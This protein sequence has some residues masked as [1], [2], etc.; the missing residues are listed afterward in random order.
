MP[1]TVSSTNCRMPKCLNAQIHKCHA[2]ANAQMSKCHTNA[3]QMQ[4]HKRMPNAQLHKC[5]NLSSG[6]CLTYWTAIA[7]VPPT[8]GRVVLPA[9]AVTVANL[10]F[11]FEPNTAQ[12]RG[13]VL[14]CCR[15]HADETAKYC[16]KCTKQKSKQK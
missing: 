4:M 3:M 1:S 10:G 7:T 11:V 8:R 9:V 6:F 12:G 2:S 15:V 14:R 16:S 13:I 5:Q